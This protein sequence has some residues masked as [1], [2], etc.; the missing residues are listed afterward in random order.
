M[1]H[2]VVII[3]ILIGSKVVAQTA[4]IIGPIVPKT[5]FAAEL[6]GHRKVVRP[7][8]LFVT[9]GGSE[10]GW[11]GARIGARQLASRGFTALALPYWGLKGLPAAMDRIELSFFQSVFS[12]LRLL[13]PQTKIVFWGSSRGG[14]LALLLATFPW[15]QDATVSLAG[16]AIGMWGYNV[17]SGTMTPAWM[18][19]GR[20]LP[21]LRPTQWPTEWVKLTEGVGY[22]SDRK[23]YL[24]AI[25]QIVPAS[26]VV[27]RLE[28]SRGP[29]LIAA[30]QD[31]QIWPSCALTK[32]GWQRLQAARRKHD[33]YLCLKKSGH[34][35][36]LP[37]ITDPNQRYVQLANG[38]II[39]FGGDPNAIADNAAALEGAFFAWLVN[40]R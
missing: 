14:E 27:F 37:G 38:T 26:P 29:L 4:S 31:D 30:A 25:R 9:V 20:A 24:L 21:H 19:R 2:L 10:G 34:D 1:V 28:R 5:S 16:S 15:A 7:D 12:E 17:A 8:L 23:A 11:D 39:N 32:P 40:L 33:V 35:L 36:A 13:Y 6:Y 3:A 18:Y 22:D